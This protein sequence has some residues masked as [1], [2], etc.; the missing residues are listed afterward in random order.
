MRPGAE[1]FDPAA[2]AGLPSAAL[3]KQIN[4]LAE[5]AGCIVERVGLALG[6]PEAVLDQAAC[7]GLQPVL[8]DRLAGIFKEIE[9]L[10]LVLAQRRSG[11]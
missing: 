8:Q 3:I 1:E 4:A 10:K 5:E 7:A 2:F 11:R 9:A 6:P